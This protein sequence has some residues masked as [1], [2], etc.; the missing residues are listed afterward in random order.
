MILQQVTENDLELR[1]GRG[2]MTSFNLNPLRVS[3]DCFILKDSNCRCYFALMH[4]L[5]CIGTDLLNWWCGSVE[6]LSGN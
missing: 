5:S 4:F 2:Y 6:F 3:E 1:T